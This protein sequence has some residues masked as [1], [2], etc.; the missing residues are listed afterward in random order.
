MIQINASAAQAP[1]AIIGKMEKKKRKS[2][3]NKV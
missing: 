3:K 2:K 1:K